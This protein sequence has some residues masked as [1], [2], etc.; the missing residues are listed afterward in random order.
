MTLRGKISTAIAVPH[1]AG[2][3]TRIGAQAGDYVCVTGE[4]G[5][6]IADHHITFTPR[7]AEA[8]ELLQ[9][10]GKSLHSMI[11]ISDGLGKDASHLASETLQLVINTELLPLR[12]GATIV[13]AISD[14]EDY[15]LLFTSES[16]PPSRLATV[17]GKVQLG[18]PK[19]ITTTDED[20]SSFG[21]NHG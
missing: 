13:N 1:K 3:I 19:V 17:I 5:N 12:K 20:I 11:D 8:Q 14:G 4:L 9:L 21:W 10:L 2:A 16:K 7:I 15:E 6:S 18:E